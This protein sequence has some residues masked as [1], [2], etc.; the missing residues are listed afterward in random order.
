MT[1]ISQAEAGWCTRNVSQEKPIGLAHAVS[2]DFDS[3][4]IKLPAPDLPVKV[5]GC[6]KNFWEEKPVGMPV[7][8][9]Y[10]DVLLM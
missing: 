1:L 8:T 5:G 6:C 2:F 10:S 9:P 4:P 7:C 3:L